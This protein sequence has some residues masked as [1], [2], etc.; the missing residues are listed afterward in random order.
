MTVFQLIRWNEQIERFEFY[1]CRHFGG[2]KSIRTTLKELEPS[3][4]N[5]DMKIYEYMVMNKHEYA[6]WK[7]E[8]VK[9]YADD[10]FPVCVAVHH[11]F[12]I[13]HTVDYPNED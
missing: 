11:Q 8:S 10:Q 12:P 3:E 4:V 5:L 13:I 2:M 1:T 9:K 7:G 6:D